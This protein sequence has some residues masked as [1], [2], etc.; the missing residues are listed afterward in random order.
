MMQRL[1]RTESRL[2][3][4]NSQLRHPLTVLC[5][6]LPVLDGI[7]KGLDPRFDISEIA[8]PYAQELLN[9]KEAGTQIF[10]RVS[11]TPRL[12]K[13][14]GMAAF[15]PDGRAVLDGGLLY[16]FWHHLDSIR[17]V[18]VDKVIVLME[19]LWHEI[20]LEKQAE[21]LRYVRAEVFG[22]PGRL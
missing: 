16:L 14:P 21:V 5:L 4:W 20:G 10:L 22:I 15:E 3:L 7:G 1:P 9:L 18:G 6:L 12:H 8:K 13:S 17:L 2:G 11:A 19:R